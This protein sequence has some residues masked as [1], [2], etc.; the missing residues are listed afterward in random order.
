MVFLMNTAANAK[1][2]L[3]VQEIADRLKSEKVL[4]TGSK[5]IYLNTG[6]NVL[7]FNRRFYSSSLYGV[8]GKNFG[9]AYMEQNFLQNDVVFQKLSQVVD[10]GIIFKYNVPWSFDNFFQILK[11]YE[12]GIAA[13]EIVKKEN[14][15]LKEAYKIKRE[16]Y[17][18]KR[19]EL[20]EAYEAELEAWKDAKEE[21]KK[22][23]KAQLAEWQEAFDKADES[24]KKF[25]VQPEEIPEPAKPAEPDYGEKP[26]EPPLKALPKVEGIREQRL[27]S[28]IAFRILKRFRF[29]KVKGT[30]YGLLIKRE[31]DLTLSLDNLAMLALEDIEKEEFLSFIEANDVDF[32]ASQ[33]IKQSF[34]D[35]D[36]PELLAAIDTSL[37]ELIYEEDENED[38]HLV[39]LAPIKPMHAASMLAGGLG[40]YYNEVILDG[41]VV[42][43]KGAMVK[44]SIERKT[45]LQGKEIT[46]IIETQTQKLGV[47][48]LSD[49]SFSLM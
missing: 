36:A 11:S 34:F 21:V 30:E 22:A 25:I 8:N 6:D 26:A 39:P 15:E 49:F 44:E 19:R 2:M 38:I 29:C 42:A 10:R 33:N 20:K 27:D 17:R 47:Y 45:L 5:D 46:E 31:K 23:N 40:E 3:Q 37:S 18:E 14:D 43:L 9:L 4:F 16:A 48:N 28:T 1:Q 13:Q 41:D 12:A 32:K 7:Q 24:L 35:M